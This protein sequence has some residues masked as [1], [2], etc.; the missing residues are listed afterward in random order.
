MLAAGLRTIAALSR[1]GGPRETEDATMSN[2]ELAP[3]TKRDDA[4]ALPPQHRR[5]GDSPMGPPAVETL[6][7]APQIERLGNLQDALLAK[8]GGPGDFLSPTRKN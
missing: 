1:P 4:P 5:S 7:V 8:T 2:H 6:Y 3:H